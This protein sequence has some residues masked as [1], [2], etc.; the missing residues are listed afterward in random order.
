M[1]Q[2]D[3][4][5]VRACIVS[6]LSL[7]KS[8]HQYCS[9]HLARQ[10]VPSPIAFEANRH[11]EEIF[12]IYWRGKDSGMT[13]P[14]AIDKVIL[15][16]R[17]ETAN[18]YD[19]VLS[20]HLQIG[21]YLYKSYIQ[22]IDKRRER[23]YWLYNTRSDGEIIEIQTNLAR[24]RPRYDADQMHLLPARTWAEIVEAICAI[25]EEYLAL[26]QALAATLKENR[27]FR[28][29][30]WRARAARWSIAIAVVVAALGQSDKAL[31]NL[32]AAKAYIATAATRFLPA[33]SPADGDK[34]AR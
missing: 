28:D 25:C 33:A 2:S 15:R 7:Y 6:E 14:A 4:E 24:K 10:H 31:D 3:L 18:C 17:L 8:A 11:M 22:Q 16:I 27:K 13:V 12:S 30:L 19:H 20:R 9:R 32:I 29:D 34:G 1:D 26:N 5:Q 23:D 21:N